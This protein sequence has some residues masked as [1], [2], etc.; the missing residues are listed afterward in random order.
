MLILVGAGNVGKTT[1]V[2]RLKS[3]TKGTMKVDSRVMTDGIDIS[4]IKLKNPKTN[5]EIIFTVY[6]FAGQEEY[7]HT[8]ALFVR[9]D[10]IFVVLHKYDESDSSDAKRM[11]KELDI[12]LKM[13]ESFAL[14]A[15]VIF[16]LTHCEDSKNR[17]SKKWLDEL[18]DR[19]K[20]LV[21]IRDSNEGPFEIDSVS[22]RNIETIK[23]VMISEAL[24]YDKTRVTIPPTFFNLKDSL[25]QLVQF[26]ITSET[27]SELAKVHVKDDMTVVARD[28]FKSWGI[29]YILS[30]GD[31]VLKPQKLADVLA[32]VFTKSKDSQER[33]RSSLWGG[34]FKHQQKVLKAIWG[35]FPKELW[36]PS[37]TGTSIPFIDLLH[38]SGLA[39]PVFDVKGRALRKSLVPSM[40]QTVPLDLHSFESMSDKE[41]IESIFGVEMKFTTIHSS[42]S[43]TFY[44]NLPPTFLGQL[45]SRVSSITVKGGEW[46]SGCSLQSKDGKSCAIVYKT[47]SGKEVGNI[48][49][50]ISGG[51]DEKETTARDSVLIAIYD[52]IKD[53]YDSLV[54]SVDKVHD[55]VLVNRISDSSSSTV[56]SKFRFTSYLVDVK[57]SSKVQVGN[58]IDKNS[59]DLDDFMSTLKESLT[60][61]ESFSSVSIQQLQAH[62]NESVASVNNYLWNAIPDLLEITIGQPLYSDMVNKLLG[63]WL[64]F[65]DPTKSNLFHAIHFYYN[66][67]DS[68]WHSDLDYGNN[69]LVSI[70]FEATSSEVSTHQQHSRDIIEIMKRVL[71]NVNLSAVLDT[72]TDTNTSSSCISKSKLFSSYSK[73]KSDDPWSLLVCMKIGN[74]VKQKLFYHEEKYYKERP[75][76]N[77]KVCRYMIIIIIITMNIII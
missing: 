39:Y 55:K 60:R 49:Y 17:G 43:L 18:S 31:I 68:K 4:E 70:P 34:Y 11:K 26:S 36:Q 9:K 64:V 7:I 59:R 46:I 28:I 42:I 25:D 12:F 69:E 14:G 77:D 3:N 37:N 15:R 13:I 29:I 57:E 22:G 53:K 33:I 65:K 2:K 16:A 73:S 62:M 38:E 76:V 19:Y 35:K 5:G 72:N 48:M 24:K 8:H 58:I 21:F 44:P 51:T 63:L 47:T 40:L 1:L 52:L 56:P 75:K 66:D 54:C 32:C 74:K 20:R 71:P 10:S 45:Q 6:D 23:D 67:T 61:Y 41:M 50:L 27:F 30:N